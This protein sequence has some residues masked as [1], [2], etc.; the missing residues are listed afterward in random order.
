MS[1]V[2]RNSDWFVPANVDSL[3]DRFFNDGFG[4][5]R[6]VF[7]PRTDISENEKGFEIQLAVPGMKKEDF[8]VDLKNGKLTISGERK[9][10]N[11]E[12]GKNYH[13]IQTEFGSFK[14]S[15]QLPDNVNEKKIEASYEDG[16]L[17]ISI[18]KDKSKKLESA[19][20]VK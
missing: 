18:P 14:K 15:F 12:K 11:E 9:F 4:N 8:T 10:N 13:S 2:K 7:V 1:L 20:V 16:I 6:S 3:F 5:T 19:I 17:N